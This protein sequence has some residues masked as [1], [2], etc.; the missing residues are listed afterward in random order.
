MEL[1]GK[2][3]IVTGGASGI[4]RGIA[5]RLAAD[6]ARGIV[7]ADVN[8]ER[9]EGVASEVSGLAVRCD[10]SVESDIQAL[11]AATKKNYNTDEIDLRVAIDRK[12]GDYD[13]FRRWK[14]FADDSKELE[15]TERELRLVA[16]DAHRE[17]LVAV[18]AGGEPFVAG[19]RIAAFGVT[20]VEPARLDRHRAAERAG[21]PD[22]IGIAIAAIGLLGMA[23]PDWRPWLGDAG[24]IFFP[25]YAAV[26][27]VLERRT[28]R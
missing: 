8:L 19:R 5:Q 11:V 13:T 23:R 27:V 3:A 28:S 17:R 22:S 24:L 26:R 20:A 2:V 1:T 18:A 12:T 15:F 6:G 9:A 4:G 10:V 7:V 25:L 16:R 21:V 14:V